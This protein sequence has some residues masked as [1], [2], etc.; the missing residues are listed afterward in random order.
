[1]IPRSR[2]RGAVQLLLGAAALAVAASAAGAQ[3]WRTVQ[4]SRQL[5]DTAEHEVRVRYGA[6]RMS[7]VPASAR[8]L[9]SL[10]LTYDAVSADPEVRYDS[11]GRAL[12][13]GMD[14]EHV[15]LRNPGNEDNLA[16]LLLQLSPRVP[17][18]LDVETGVTRST[19]E[20]GGLAVRELKLGSGASETLVT[21][22]SA[23]RVAMRRLEASVGAAGLT[24]RGIGNAGARD[25]RVRGGVGS[26][27]LDFSGAWTENVVDL[28][29]ELALGGARVTVP[30]DVGIRVEM[31]R[32]LAGFSHP[33][34]E[35][36]DGAYYS[37]NWERA[38]RRLRIR[39]E[40]AFGGLT[41]EREGR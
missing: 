30:D 40:T 20:L 14:V 26:V 28:A 27:V 10:E 41:I 38:T 21:F 16:E 29:L 31:T 39:A 35:R 32:F 24:I 18:S 36:R 13:V 8:V 15:R 22:D 19:L 12:R 33:G 23:N 17:L 9:Y 37:S 25:V 4:S 7:I 34:L 2:L 11:A 6:G 1:M 3:E 5:R